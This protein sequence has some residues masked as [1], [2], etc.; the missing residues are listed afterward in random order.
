[1][2]EVSRDLKNRIETDT[3]SANRF[4]IV[5]AIFD[6]I[7]CLGFSLTTRS[8]FADIKYLGELVQALL[9]AS[10][11]ILA[12]SALMLVEIKKTSRD[13]LH[14]LNLFIRIH[15]ENRITSE[16]IAITF[17]QWSLGASIISLISSILSL[18]FNNPVAT[19]ISIFTFAAQI[20]YFISALGLS[21]FLQFI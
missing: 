12:F 14:S 9:V 2:D 21:T 10:T 1:M 3:K 18:I 7:L 11:A 8:F 6:S 15:A 19:I 5:I 17:L 4:S 20:Y 16:A 13:G